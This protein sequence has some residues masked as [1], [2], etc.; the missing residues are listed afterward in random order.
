MRWFLSLITLHAVLL[1]V[2]LLWGLTSWFGLH[3]QRGLSSA[4]PLDLIVVLD[5][6]SSRLAA[7]IPSEVQGTNP[8]S[9]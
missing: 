4:Q 1:S 5:G 7:A 6:G 9:C 3:P 8:T 2:V